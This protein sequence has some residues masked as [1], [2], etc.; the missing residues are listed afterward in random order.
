MQCYSELTAPTAVTTSLS[1]HLTSPTSNN[2]LVGKGSLLQ[3]FE[4][5]VVLSD[6]EGS[7][8]ANTNPKDTA[9]AAAVKFDARLHDDNGL[10]SSF[11]GGETLVF[12]KDRAHLTKLVLI[13][14]IPLDGTILGMVRVAVPQSSA[15][16]GSNSAF[17]STT[18]GDFAL[19]A[20]RSAKMVLADWNPATQTL[21]PMSIH[22]FEK[23]S[24]V[25]APWEMAVSETVTYLQADPSSRCAALKFGARSVSFVPFKQADEEMEMMDEW[26]EDLD[27]PRPA[28]VAAARPEQPDGNSSQPQDKIEVPYTT[29][30]C[31]RLPQLDS[32]LTHIVHF[33]FLYE[34]R[35]PTFGVLCSNDSPASGVDKKDQMSYRVF[36]LDIHHKASTTIS[37]VSGL[38]NG[39]FK[40]VPL[41]A[42]AGGALLVGEN[43][44]IHVDQ[45]GRTN[46]VAVNEFAKQCTDWSL[47]DQS[48]LKL[49][50]EHC[51]VELLSAEH[52]EVLLI[53]NDGR[54][55]LVNLR[56]DGRT[57][58]SVNVKMISPEA[59]GGLVKCRV[60][61][62]SRLSKNSMFVGS[63]EGDSLVL[64]WTRKLAQSTKRKARLL[65]DSFDYDEED[66]DFDDMEEDDDLYGGDA[67][68][69]QN[70]HD[71]NGVAKS[72][73]LVF[74]VHDSLLSMAP[75]RAMTTGKAAFFPN[76]EEETLSRGV[77]A[78]L[79][80]TCAVGKGQSGAIAV[81]NREIQPKVIGRF[82][83]PEARG[84][85]TMCAR[86]PV[87]KQLTSQ[88]GEQKDTKDTSAAAAGA[89][90]DLSGQF[91]RFMIV[92]KE[93][94]DGYETSDV[95]A[96][97][98]A[99]FEALTGTE[100][101]PAAGFTVEAGVMGK[102]NRVVQV[103]KSEVRC[104]DGSKFFL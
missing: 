50:L 17:K 48:G 10:E 58:S 54:L 41:P 18:G 72:G 101:E 73:E 67:P 26:D 5:K 56:I 20:L 84:F 1:I 102:H 33:A 60:S 81:V 7:H 69:G 32:F 14:E 40:V 90:V 76:S 78:D 57:V 92:S 94:I 34:Y 21:E 28:K 66:L 13:A 51:A 87:P 61:C 9:A 29:S 85:W 27:G 24:L 44:L 42:P 62:A 83:F 43:E 103:L 11:L 23:E 77:T 35:E 68:G 96:L 75:I 2:L 93:D 95:Y 4:T 6:L 53:L 31:L 15:T 80:L 46:G 39:L 64:G 45:A 8:P 52:G 25:G 99:G 86:K 104:Y 22:Y 74:R 30:F 70:T 36:T 97:T 65:D 49:K 3:I 79:T 82:E 71:A 38:P 59:G 55:A 47:A 98:S 12:S 16:E 100:F 63:T 19:V 88:S 91:D 37:S 89:G